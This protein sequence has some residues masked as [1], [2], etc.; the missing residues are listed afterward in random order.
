[1]AENVNI[2]HGDR[3]LIGTN[4]Y[5]LYCDPKKNPNEMVEYEVAMKEANAD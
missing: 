5:W 2:K 4:H 3:I 1:M